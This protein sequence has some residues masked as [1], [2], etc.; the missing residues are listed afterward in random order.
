[1]APFRW[2]ST[3]NGVMVATEAAARRPKCTADWEEI[4]QRLS[5]EFSTENRAVK[6]T[7]RA[8]RE[9]LDRLI[10]KYVEE[11]KKALKKSGTEEE[12]GQLSQLLEDIYTFRKDSVEMQKKERESKKQ[13]EKDD[14]RK[15]EEMRDAAM[16]G[17]GKRNL[18][19]SD[20]EAD[21]DSDEH[22]D[23]TC[24]SAS[25]TSKGK[26]ASK[27][28]PVKIKKRA[29]KLTAIEMLEKKNERKAN[30]KELELEQRKKEFEFEKQKYEEEA[31][32]RREKL[33]LEIE[34]KR[35]FLALLKD[36]L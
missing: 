31:A 30:F 36:R 35:A 12:Y 21:A 13:K 7:G 6:L 22:S 26:K 27:A 11:D 16:V 17:L 5:T 18:E 8:C 3:S 15:A 20:D 19:G 24:S 34:E 1:M 2:P 32:E 25:S 10:A 9:R 28:K 23:D 4:A 29:S 33:Q 14:K